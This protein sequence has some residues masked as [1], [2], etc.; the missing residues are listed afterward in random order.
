[1]SYVRKLFPLLRAIV[2]FAGSI[3]LGRLL[4]T[5][6]LPAMHIPLNQMALMQDL[7]RLLAFVL[8]ACLNIAMVLLLCRLVDR[9]PLTDFRWGLTQRAALLAVLA[10]ALYVLG[11]MLLLSVLKSQ[12]IVRLYPMRFLNPTYFVLEAVSFLFTGIW[13][14]M[15]YRGYVFHTL[16]EY[17]RWPAYGLSILLFSV[18]HFTQPGDPFTWW[19]LAGLVTAAFTLTYIYDMTGSL[20]S[21][22]FVHGA[23]DFAAILFTGSFPQF[24]LYTMVVQRPFNFNLPTMLMHLSVLVLVAG[25]YWR[26]KPAVTEPAS[27]KVA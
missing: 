11:H 23:I 17:G 15:L 22:A 12:G 16:R 9:R 27:E 20:W 10:T 2:A 8:F 6:I 26:R 1:M 4:I 13:E 7:P 5:V 25:L 19:R 21:V 14:E 3:L 18:V 24:S